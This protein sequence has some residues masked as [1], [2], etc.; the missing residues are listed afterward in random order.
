M[1]SS[2]N[3]T[4]PSRWMMLPAKTLKAYR[5]WWRSPNLS[6]V[7]EFRLAMANRKNRISPWLAIAQSARSGESFDEFQGKFFTTAQSPQAIIMA[8]F[9]RLLL[10]LPDD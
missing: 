5:T 7:G 1:Q 9:G 8:D 2:E 4:H 6:V 3:L 10:G